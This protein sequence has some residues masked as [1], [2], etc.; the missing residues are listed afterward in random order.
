MD[1]KSRIE[2]LIVNIHLGKNPIFNIF[3][4]PKKL[5]NIIIY[6]IISES[7]NDTLCELLIWMIEENKGEYN[8]LL[9]LE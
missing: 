4:F 8:K 6:N 3:A 2:R 9:E 7:Q 5:N 1:G